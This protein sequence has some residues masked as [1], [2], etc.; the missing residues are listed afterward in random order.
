MKTKLAWTLSL[1][2]LSVSVLAVP[3]DHLGLVGKKIACDTYV[4]AMTEVLAKQKSRQTSY[5][6]ELIGFGGG[7]TTVLVKELQTKM[8]VGTRT[9]ARL[10]ATPE[11]SLEIEDIR[12]TAN[13]QIHPKGLTGRLI[14]S[15]GKVLSPRFT[16]TY[17]K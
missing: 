1:V 4:L 14:A 2:W 12:F 15:G 3:R 8:L 9:T 7:K 5:A 16:C 13:P 6:G 11:T 17:K 10:A